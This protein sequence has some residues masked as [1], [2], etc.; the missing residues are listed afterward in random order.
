MSR[1]VAF[2]SVRQIDLHSSRM[3]IQVGIAH[4]LYM[5]TQASSRQQTFAI[6]MRRPIL[7]PSPLSSAYRYARALNSADADIP[8]APTPNTKNMHALHL[9]TKLNKLLHGELRRQPEILQRVR[10]APKAWTL[11]RAH[12]LNISLHMH[13]L[14]RCVE[15]S[16]TR[17]QLQKM[18]QQIQ[19]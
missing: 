11:A 16:G 13:M 4:N 1:P 7:Q 14:K 3:C 9:S 18:R 8:T 10:I 17:Q 12:A 2:K 5:C 6:A 15:P 19:T